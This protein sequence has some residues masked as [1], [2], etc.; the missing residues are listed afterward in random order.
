MPSYEFR[1]ATCERE[2]TFFYKTYAAYDAASTAADART[3]PHCGSRALVRIFHR[4]TVATPD[5]R[6][7][8]RMSS[9]EMLSVLEGSDR[10]EIDTMMR[11]V[12]VDPD[13]QSAQARGWV[14]QVRAGGLPSATGGDAPKADAPKPAGDGGTL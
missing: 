2:S 4:I 7:Y 11:Q 14:E 10:G 9:G 13:V 3:C 6:D 5:A 1:C 8:A 12:G